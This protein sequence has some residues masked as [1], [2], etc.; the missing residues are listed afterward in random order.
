MGPRLAPAT[1]LAQCRPLLANC[2]RLKTQGK[3]VRLS[4]QPGPSASLGCFVRPASINAFQSGLCCPS[5]AVIRRPA[6]N[7]RPA[8]GNCSF[9]LVEWLDH[10][11]W[12]PSRTPHASTPR[13]QCH[14]RALTND[15]QDRHGRV[16]GPSA[17]GC[18]IEAGAGPG[19]PTSSRLERGCRRRRCG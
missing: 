9:Q 17:P 18:R 4:S 16:H 6:N 14:V 1:S 13:S 7:K 2:R 3:R 19:G 8:C 10:R 12:A 15:P 5:P 11:C